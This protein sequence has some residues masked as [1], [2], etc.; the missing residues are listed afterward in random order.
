LTKAKNTKCPNYN[1][2]FFIAIFRKSSGHTPY[3]PQPG[4]DAGSYDSQWPPL[5]SVTVMPTGSATT[6]AP[7]MNSHS[8][9]AYG[10]P[11]IFQGQGAVG[12]TANA[13]GN[14]LIQETAPSSSGHS[15][16]DRNG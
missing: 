7:S 12:A 2:F 14:I 8:Q 1:C 4:T 16:I 13:T 3:V 10:R 15:S 11:P 9:Q 6:F 5:P